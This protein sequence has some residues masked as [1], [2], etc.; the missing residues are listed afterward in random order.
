M[1]TIA[2]SD[3]AALAGD[4]GN[5]RGEFIALLTG[6]GIYELAERAKVKVTGNDRVR[7]LNGMVSNNVRDL[8]VGR[9]VYAFLLNPQ[10]HILGDLYI[11]KQ[12]QRLF[13]DVEKAQLANQLQLLRKYIIMDKVELTDVSSELTVIG[14]AGPNSA[15]VF[16]ASGIQ[17]PE[18]ESLSVFEVTWRDI[19]LTVIR[20]PEASQSYEIW[21]SPQHVD[22]L[23]DALGVNGAVTVSAAAWELR[24][25]ALGI[26]RYGKDIRERE[27]PQETGQMRALN[28]TKG[29]FIGQE[30]VERIRSR[31]NVHRR[32]AGFLVDGPLPVAGSR[33]QAEGKEVGEITSAASLPFEHG[34][35][36]VA[37]G[38][39]RRE[40]EDKQLVAADA[41]LSPV[42]LPFQAP[43]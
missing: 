1:A 28:F 25:I 12:E 24:R 15:A 11:Y 2:H 21:L 5:V 17:I 10:G 16:I 30:I 22:V 23:R 4:P 39:I 38:Y 43:A 19:P 13:L 18:M 20:G 6:C 27:L 41:R 32:F 34:E 31:G 8:P 7:W 33:I 29:C 37:L 40:A 3:A 26:P 9:G 42:E 35:L 36:R 14:V